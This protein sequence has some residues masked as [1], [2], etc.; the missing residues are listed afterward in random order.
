VAQLHALDRDVLYLAPAEPPRPC[1]SDR[2]AAI[3]LPMLHRIGP[4]RIK[5]GI[6]LQHWAAGLFDLGRY[7]AERSTTYNSDFR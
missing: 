2:P 6:L 3:V 5:E 4:A 1:G 7:L